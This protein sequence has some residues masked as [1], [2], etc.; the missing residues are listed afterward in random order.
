MAKEASSEAALRLAALSTDAG[1]RGVS[2]RWPHPRVGCRTGML[3]SRVVGEDEWDDVGAGHTPGFEPT[4]RYQWTVRHD[5]HTECARARHTHTHICA[6]THRHDRHTLTYS[7][8]YHP[9]SAVASLRV[10]RSRGREI[11]RGVHC[12]TV[13]HRERSRIYLAC[14]VCILHD[15]LRGHH[16]Y[17]HKH[18]S[19]LSTS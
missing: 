9:C 13:T 18:V 16:L 19:I 15:V 14:V 17:G 6:H 8:D 11:T 5:T 3:A 1:A 7:P 4:T 12:R 2:G 10:R